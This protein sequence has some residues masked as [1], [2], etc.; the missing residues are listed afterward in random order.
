M[1]S[2]TNVA[3]TMGRPF[4][5]RL[6][7]TILK[8]D[9]HWQWSNARHPIC[10][11]TLSVLYCRAQWRL[12]LRTKWKSQRA[13]PAIFFVC[14][15]V[16]VHSVRMSILLAYHAAILYYII[17]MYGGNC[18]GRE[19]EQCPQCIEIVVICKSNPWRHIPFNSPLTLLTNHVDH[20]KLWHIWLATDLPRLYKLKHHTI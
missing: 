9:W 11:Y 4:F 15:F 12:R 16:H 18:T 8:W 1:L 10:N 14:C 13:T 19:T 17:F 20:V 7:I 2:R 6:T 3:Q 5:E